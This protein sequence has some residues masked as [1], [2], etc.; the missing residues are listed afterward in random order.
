MK[1]PPHLIQYDT[2]RYDVIWYDDTAAKNSGFRECFGMSF[3]ICCL[4]VGMVLRI[5]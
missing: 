3:E 4:S 5:E 2:L 1:L